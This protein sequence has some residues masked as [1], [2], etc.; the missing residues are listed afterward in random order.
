[1][2]HAMVKWVEGLQFI[3]SDDMGHAFVIDSSKDHGGFDLGFRPGQLLLV[4]LGACTGMDV[5]SILQ[6]KKQEVTG[7][8]VH[9][10]GEGASDFPKRWL[11]MEVEYRL[12]GRG[13][14]KDAVAR[15]IQL[16]EEKYCMVRATL[17]PQVQI[18]SRFTLQDA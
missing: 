1:M 17:L 10:E 5:I 2:S 4:A 3:A 14:Q 18:T 11:R 6:K 8:E 7:F 13:L 15:A 9:V 16:S 12:K